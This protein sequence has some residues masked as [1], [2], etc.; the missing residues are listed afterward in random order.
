MYGTYGRLPVSGVC[1]LRSAFCISITLETLRLCWVG[2]INLG[3]VNL[4]QQVPDTYSHT[5]SYN[6]EADINVMNMA[7]D[8]DTMFNSWLKA[9]KKWVK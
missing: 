9:G 5:V 1:C 3:K 4:K 8:I 2:F 6:T 7:P